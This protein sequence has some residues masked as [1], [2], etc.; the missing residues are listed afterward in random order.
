MGSHQLPL[1]IHLRDDEKMLEQ[2]ISSAVIGEIRGMSASMGTASTCLGFQTGVRDFRREAGD[3]NLVVKCT[4]KTQLEEFDSLVMAM[5]PIKTQFN[6]KSRFVL[7]STVILIASGCFG[8]VETHPQYSY[9]GVSVGISYYRNNQTIVFNNSTISMTI[10]LLIQQNMS[11]F[12]NGYYIIDFS[13]RSKSYEI[14]GLI[15]FYKTSVSLTGRIQREKPILISID[16]NISKAKSRVDTNYESEKSKLQVQIDL[17]SSV[18]M[19]QYDLT[20]RYSDYSRIDKIID[21]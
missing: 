17:I 4:L 3:R 20:I 13:K 11:S 12:T 6:N 2:G 8:C 9:E 10:N 21:P 14:Y 15:Y 5:N 18:L 19:N 16:G 1:Q 7:M